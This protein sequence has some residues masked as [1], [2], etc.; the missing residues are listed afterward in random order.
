MENPAA[1]AGFFHFL[2]VAAMAGSTTRRVANKSS[3]GRLPS[4]RR[5]LTAVTTAVLDSPSLVLISEL[6]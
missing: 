5:L 2:F 6:I 4:V 1:M 3:R